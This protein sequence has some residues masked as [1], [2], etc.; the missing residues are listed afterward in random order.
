MV[1]FLTRI[2]TYLLVAVAMAS[3]AVERR[4]GLPGDGEAKVVAYVQGGSIPALIHA[5]KL[6]H[7]CYAFA[8]IPKL[9]YL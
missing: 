7:I 1:R 9:H 6:T 2:F 4:L 3:G 5:Q 8:R